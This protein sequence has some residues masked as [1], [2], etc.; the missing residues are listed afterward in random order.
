MQQEAGQATVEWVGL[1]LLAALVLGGLLA[2]VPRRDDSLGGVVAERIVC[3]VRGACGGG[4]AS[5]PPAAPAPAP[6]PRE[7]AAAPATAPP[8]Q[9]RAGA[10]APAPP[11]PVSRA[12]A[13]D[14]FQ[15][16]RGVAE[17]G[18]RTWIL[19]LGYKRWR[20]EL[21]HPRPPQDPLPLEEA[22]RIANSCLN[23]LSFLGGG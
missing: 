12:R 1:V 15:R 5:G 16:L 11:P 6:P 18:K 4:K 8:P 20:Y 3:A 23:P 22:L 13:A 2:L 10:P 9:E 7:R 17:I 21:E 19:C 14:A